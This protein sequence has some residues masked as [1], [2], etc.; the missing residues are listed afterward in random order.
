MCKK[1][2]MLAKM[3]EVPY[4]QGH[5][6]SQRKSY[7]QSRPNC[8]SLL[9]RQV[10]A[11]LQEQSLINQECL[12][13]RGKLVLAEGCTA[14]HNVT[15]LELRAV[16]TDFDDNAG[17]I[18]ANNGGPLIDEEAGVLLQWLADWDQSSGTQFSK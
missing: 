15:W 10:A 1:S 11:L 4:S 18:A 3:Q 13:K 2:K 6:Q 16:R 8:S 12:L 5:V 9:H 7:Q 14:I 17:T